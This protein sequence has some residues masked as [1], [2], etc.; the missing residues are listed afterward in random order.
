MQPKTDR[1]KPILALLHNRYS[2]AVANFRLTQTV[3]GNVRAL[4]VA[5]GSVVRELSRE[6]LAEIVSERH[7]DKRPLNTTTVAR[8]EA[9]E[10]EPDLHSLRIMA[11]LAGVSMEQF[12]FGAPE[13][14]GETSHRQER[15]NHPATTDLSGG[16]VRPVARPAAATRGNKGKRPPTGDR[17]GQAQPRGRPPRS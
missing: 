11:E 17:P 7:P 16:A 5:L 12:A 8:W 9:G 13:N 10:S 14:G 3:S 2:L 4:R 1:R 15:V 6:A